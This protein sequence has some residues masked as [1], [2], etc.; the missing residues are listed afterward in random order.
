ME[1]VAVPVSSVVNLTQAFGN[2]TESSRFVTRYIS[3]KHADLFFADAVVLVEG[4]AERMMLP[5]F[6][7]KDFQRL[8]QG[9]IT[10]IEVGGSHAHKLKGLMDTLGSGRIDFGLVA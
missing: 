5:N 8:N 4:S 6:I 1:K 9:Y 10:I 7:K 2:E 3:A